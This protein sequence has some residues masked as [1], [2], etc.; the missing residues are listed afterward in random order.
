MKKLLI[1][2]ICLLIL[3]VH[4]QEETPEANEDLPTEESPASEPLTISIAIVVLGI[5][6][7]DLE[8]GVYNVDFFLGLYC[9]R[10]CSDEARAI[11]FIGTTGPDSLNVEENLRTPESVEY[12]VQAVLSRNDIDL[13]RFPFDSHHLNIII[14]SE[15]LDVS[16]LVYTPYPDIRVIDEDVQIPGWQINPEASFELVRKNYGVG[17]EYP[18]LILSMELY[19]TGTAA[20]IRSILPAL[21]IMIISLLS[22]Y[23]PDLSQRSGVAGGILLALLV[24]HFSVVDGIPQVA[25]PMY[26]DA[27]ML[28]NNALILMQFSLTVWEIVMERREMPAEQREKIALRLLMG[29]ILLWLVG[30]AVLILLFLL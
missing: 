6:E 18:R 2:L 9:S 16:Q 25:Y 20:F 21:I 14:E 22:S 10:E 26:F 5:S 3:P 7:F 27:F 17:A 19:R 8:H 4:A 29:M 28:A 30:Q 23:V 13:S 15:V 24:H 1:L 12:R 11:D